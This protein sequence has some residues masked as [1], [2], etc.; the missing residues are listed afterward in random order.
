MR[1]RRGFDQGIRVA[2][3]YRASD[4]LNQERAMRRIPLPRETCFYE[5][6]LSAIRKVRPECAEQPPPLTIEDL[7]ADVL[8]FLNCSLEN[9]NHGFMEE[10][11][12]QAFR[13]D[14]GVVSGVVTNREGLVV[15]CG[16]ALSQ[17]DQL[18][19]CFHPLATWE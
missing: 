12:A 11:V 9:V 3:L 6:F 14:C 2:V 16:L 15:S 5:V 17:S 19:N 1:L 13:S 4:G 8:V 18:V 7:H 10:L